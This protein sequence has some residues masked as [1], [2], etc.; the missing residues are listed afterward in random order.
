MFD[1]VLLQYGTPGVILIGV[2][3]VIRYLLNDNLKI[4]REMEIK[5]KEVKKI[6][7]DKI[8]GKKRSISGLELEIKGMKVEQENIK[9]DITEIKETNIRIFDK[10]DEIHREFLRFNNK[11]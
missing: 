11:G 5:V 2:I 1:S 6:T 7:D 8:D 4:R 3:F 9:Q 10:M